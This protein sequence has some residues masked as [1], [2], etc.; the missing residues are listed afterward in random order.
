MNKLGLRILR[1]KDGPMINL[2]VNDGEWTRKVVDIRDILKLY[3]GNDL[4]RFALFMKF[5][6][7]GC[8]ITVARRIIGRMGENVAAWIYI[9]NNVNI[10]GVRLF[11][12]IGVVKNVLSG[13]RMD[14]E[15][16]TRLFS[17]TYPEC[18][19]A[20]YTPSAAD[21]LYAKRETGF[22]PLADILGDNRYQ[23]YYAP[24][25][26][27]LIDEPGVTLRITDPAVVNLSTKPFETAFVL[28]PPM[29]IDIPKGVSVHFAHGEQEPFTHPRRFAKGENVSLLFRRQG[30]EDI[31]HHETV[32][33]QDQICSIPRYDW[34]VKVTRN[35]F[36]V[37]DSYDP[38]NILTDQA[39][40]YINGNELG[41]TG[42]ALS[43]REA[44]N[45]CIMVKA[46]DFDTKEMTVDLLQRRNINVPLKPSKRSYTWPIEMANDHRATLTIQSEYLPTD[47]YDSPLRGYEV[48][49]NGEMIYVKADKEKERFI[50]FAAAT[51][52]ALLIW[53]IV[54]LCGYISSHDFKFNLGW[55]LIE[56]TDAPP[57]TKTDPATEDQQQQSTDGESGKGG[58][59]KGDDK[60]GE[61]DPNAPGL[62]AAVAYLDQH[63][64]WNRDSLNRYPD[65]KGLF[66]EMNN[67]NFEKI[68]SRQGRLAN[69]GSFKELCTQIRANEAKTFTPPYNT[70]S[71]DYRIKVAKYITAI[72]QPVKAAATTSPSG[73]STGTSGTGS[74]GSSTKADDRDNM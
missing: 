62:E 70:D 59:E 50:G 68:L 29:A 55:P 27:I 65:L 45:A 1:F 33:E 19:A 14:P 44:H 57:D 58:E 24:Y 72:N 56:V 54:S 52:I 4:E 66:E 13:S 35:N 7:T 22:Y 43:E 49:R 67:Y 9:P 63:E 30:Y 6:E 53:G 25:A 12:I 10:S 17:Q 36:T 40:I 42:L 23:P 15:I 20:A 11:E 46:D 48:D 47:R 37:V 74:P 73:H 8:Y 60:T 2:T 26:S 31:L 32:I 28:C 38:A 5:S 64:V 16:L 3:D 18:E 61:V 39:R 34:K 21:R 71:N 51:A 69:S 41:Y